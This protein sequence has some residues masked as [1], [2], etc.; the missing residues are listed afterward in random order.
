[1]ESKVI[2]FSLIF[3]SLFFYFEENAPFKRQINLTDRSLLLALNESQGTS[4]FL[5]TEKPATLFLI[6]PSRVNEKWLFPQ[7]L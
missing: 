7:K 2:D 1:M 3:I 5:P 6:F 4:N